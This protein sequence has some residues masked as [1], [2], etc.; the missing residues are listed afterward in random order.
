MDDFWSHLRK[1]FWDLSAKVGRTRT[2]GHRKGHVDK[3]TDEYLSVYRVKRKEK[4]KQAS[5]MRA[6]QRVRDRQCSTRA[7]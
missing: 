1:M 6:V 5:K 7:R 3:S 2:S 4:N